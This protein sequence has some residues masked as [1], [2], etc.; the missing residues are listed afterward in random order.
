M[1]RY[2]FTRHIFCAFP[3]ANFESGAVKSAA[4]NAFEDIVIKL[5]M[6]LDSNPREFQLVVRRAPLA[7]AAQAAYNAA[8]DAARKAGPGAPPPAP[9][10]RRVLSVLF[11]C[12]LGGV[13]L[14]PVTKLAACQL[15]ASGTLGP[16]ELLS[17]ELELG[18]ACVTVSTPHHATIKEQLLPLVIT[19]G[20]DAHR[21][22]LVYENRSE[23]AFVSLGRTLLR[24]LAR[25]PGG[26]LV[27]WPSGD[28]MRKTLACW[29]RCGVMH[30]LECLIP[31]ANIIR[32]DSTGG[33]EAS[34]RAIAAYR[35]A[36]ADERAPGCSALLLAVMRG[37]A[38]EGSDFKD[39][40][41]RASFVIGLPLPPFADTAVAMKRAYND[42]RWGGGPAN[43]RSGHSWYMAEGVRCASQAIGRVIRHAGDYGAAVLL[44]CRYATA[45]GPRH[46][47]GVRHMLPAYLQDD[48]PAGG[49]AA[50]AGGAAGGAAAGAAAAAAPPDT[51]VKVGECNAA[52]PLLE[53]FF[54][55]RCAMA[56]AAAAAAVA[57]AAG[58][59]AAAAGSAAIARA[60]AAAVKVEAPAAAAAVKTE[61]PAALKTEAAP[62]AGAAAADA[63]AAHAP[64]AAAPPVKLEAMQ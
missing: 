11:A 64:P 50:G 56:A 7:E 23:D 32:D 58:G 17:A 38:S 54:K 52:L 6:L 59:A 63:G 40:A 41:A 20:P 61:A 43:P 48:A 15:F 5:G 37:R 22:E 60:A 19:S 8:A 2:A 10:P 30:Q 14:A 62:H 36:A 39:A 28:M 12:L 24:C 51:F 47:R 18:D 3:A 34:G 57:A 44:D 53:A 31:P 45:A 27:F 33:A 42:A 4:I 29:E 35:A 21:F 26:S 13:A 49:A 55:N 46:S 25:I 9:P 1:P 16:P